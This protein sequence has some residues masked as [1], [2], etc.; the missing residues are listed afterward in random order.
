MANDSS[1]THLHVLLLE[2]PNTRGQSS[3]QLGTNW[4]IS[5]IYTAQIGPRVLYALIAYL[6]YHSYC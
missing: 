5:W 1:M 3:K 4:L 2:E 6:R